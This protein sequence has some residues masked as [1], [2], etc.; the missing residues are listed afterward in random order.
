[1]EVDALVEALKEKFDAERD[2]SSDITKEDGIRYCP[3]CGEP[4]Q[5]WKTILNKEQL[6]PIS[7]KCERDK[8]AERKKVQRQSKL[9]M[10]RSEAFPLKEMESYRFVDAEES[11][12]IKVARKYV[13]NFE[14]FKAKGKGIMFYGSI[15]CG[16]TYAACCI[17]NALIERSISVKM[18]KFSTLMR[19]LWSVKEKAEMLD[20]LNNHTLLIIDDFGT[21]ND[22]EYTKEA[23]FD[24]IDARYNAKLPTIITS[25][26]TGKEMKEEQDVQKRRIYSR[27]T[28]MCIPVRCL[29]DD[30]RIIKAKEDYENMKGL[31]G[32]NKDDEGNKSKEDESEEFEDE[33]V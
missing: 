10:I 9:E 33:N 8:E 7:C 25:N 31:L 6:V 17:G 4:K 16:K 32:L 2:N 14:E 27:V 28:E 24:V 5:T 12:A 19:K 21:E 18:V 26:L 22:T 3:V 20:S 13:D 1:M 15:G 29:G 11:E 30:R 23:I